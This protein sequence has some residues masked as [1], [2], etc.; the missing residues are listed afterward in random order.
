MGVILFKKNLDFEVL[1]LMEFLFG[2]FKVNCGLFC[3]FIYLLC[4][5]YMLN[6]Y[7][8]ILILIS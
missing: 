6:K 3:G 7:F 2:K 5:C 1:F 8:V 4:L